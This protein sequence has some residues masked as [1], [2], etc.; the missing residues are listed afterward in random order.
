[1][2][3]ILGS[4][5]ASL[6]A[7]ERLMVAGVEVR[8]TP[9][10]RPNGFGYRE[11]PDGRKVENGC[12][13]LE[14]SY[15]P[16]DDTVGAW[17]PLSEYRPG[18]NHRPWIGTIG[19]YVRWLIDVGPEVERTARVGQY[20]VP[21]PFLSGDPSSL[22]QLLILTDVDRVHGD[23]EDVCDE[24]AERVGY[25]GPDGSGAVAAHTFDEACRVRL[26]DT[27][28]RN[29]IWP[30]FHKIAGWADVP[31]EQHRKVWL[32]MVWPQSVLDALQRRP[33]Y[34]PVRPMHFGCA[35]LVEALERATVD[36]APGNYWQR[37]SP[38]F[39]LADVDSSGGAP[40]GIAVERPRSVLIGVAWIADE[41]APGV[42]WLIDADDPVFRRTW[43]GDDICCVEYAA[44]A[45]I[46]RWCYDQG[47]DLLDKVEVRVPIGDVVCDDP[48]AIGFGNLGD[49][50]VQGLAAADRLIRE[51]G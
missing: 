25:Y 36:A 48:R 5:V 11:L 21:D 28:W 46:D 31:W 45:N 18:L 35:D 49:Q 17:H 4:S 38:S 40:I 43:R 51:K 10:G 1:M 30:V 26:G 44:G 23:L 39:D 20:S 7:T 14:L 27:L 34:K 6:V 19:S 29:V 32:P 42:E 33:S 13:L 37:F 12:R 2:I 22:D 16:G 8:R 3:E 41:H 50:I 9:T 15:E 24:L 47:H